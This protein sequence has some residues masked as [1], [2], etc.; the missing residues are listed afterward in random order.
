MLGARAPFGLANACAVRR[1][2]GPVATDAHTAPAAG[3][4]FGAVIEH[5]R[6]GRRR[7]GADQTEVR[8]ADEIADCFCDWL[9]QQFRTAPMPLLRPL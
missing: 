9:Q 6:T 4:A 8:V 2:L 1:C 5:Q 3:V 7:A